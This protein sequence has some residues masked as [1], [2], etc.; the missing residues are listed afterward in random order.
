MMGTYRSK[1][2]TLVLAIA[3]AIGL[4]C[5]GHQSGPQ[6]GSAIVVARVSL[7]SGVSGVSVTV[8]G[9][10][11]PTPISKTLAAA[12]S[13]YS[14]WIDNLPPSN[15]YTFTAVALDDSTPQK[16]LLQGAVSRQ[17][18]QNART[19]SITIYLNA[20][21]SKPYINAAPVIDSVSATSL[22]AS[23]GE[24]LQF[25]AMA[26]DPDS[27]ETA[28]LAFTWAATC[29]TLKSIMNTPGDDSFGSRSV[30]N[31]TAPSVGQ[32]C[33]ISLLVMDPGKHSTATSLDITVGKSLGQSS[34]Q[35]AVDGA[36]VVSLLS[37]T[38]GQLPT[39]GSSVL[40]V[41]ASDPDG[42][43]LDY[44]W[45]C[46]CPGAFDTANLAT[47][48]FT[49]ASASSATS[50]TFSVTVSD[51]KDAQG[52]AKNKSENH[53][54][55]AVG[56]PSIVYSP[57]FGVAYQSSDSF[58]DGQNV[59]LAVEAFDPAGSEISYSW[60]SSTSATP[61]MS[62]PADLGFDET[63]FTSAAV[64]TA[65]TGFPTTSMATATVT[66][67]SLTSSLSSSYTFVLLPAGSLCVTQS[68][69]CPAG[70]VCDPATSAC[71]PFSQ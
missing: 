43:M 33:T 54:T 20:V 19:A 46:S 13:Q 16:V 59:L 49:L 35:I 56:E 71:I 53:L 38:P 34:I 3:S 47:T 25:Q 68:I 69:A 22:T 50:C 58:N 60:T 8:S 66:A 5:D 45:S 36:P 67:T 62:A 21:S 27:G 1:Y 6:T 39:G 32:V 7:A 17:V 31:Y 2:S 10:K 37:A 61:V 18:I 65:P 9:S 55:L 63:P 30:T 14:A 42:D 64:W 57:G 41:F 70:Q 12:D 4:S 28:Q 44:A 52:N 29:G 23:Y 51:G 26:H 11:L 40:N 15:D 24:T 48:T